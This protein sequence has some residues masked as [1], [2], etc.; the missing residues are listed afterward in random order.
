MLS[1]GNGKLDFSAWQAGSLFPRPHSK[2]FQIILGSKF[3]FPTK[4][5]SSLIE[6][7]GTSFGVLPKKREGCTLSLR[8]QSFFQNKKKGRLGIEKASIKNDS[9]L[10]ILTWRFMKIPY[11]LWVRVLKAKYSNCDWTCSTSAFRIW[12]S[13]FKGW[14]SYIEASI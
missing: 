10:M 2:A 13:F 9:M 5:N 1:W 8:I 12:K 7:R 3:P 14:Q 6:L 4:S 11:N